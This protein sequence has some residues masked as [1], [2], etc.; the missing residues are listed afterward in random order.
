[1]NSN[2]ITLYTLF[3]FNFSP[4]FMWQL[5]KLWTWKLF[6]LQN[7]TILVLG[8]SSFEQWF[9]FWI[10]AHLKHFLEITFL[11]FGVWTTRHFMCKISFSLPDFVWTLICYDLCD[12]SMKFHLCSCCGLKVIRFSRLRVKLICNV[13]ISDFLLNFLVL[14]RLNLF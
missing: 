8:K 2:E 4:N 14:F 11:N 1:M 10:F 7:S 12:M 9:V 13:F 6:S 5:E 3:F